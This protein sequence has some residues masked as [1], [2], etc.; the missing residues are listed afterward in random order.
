MTSIIV[1]YNKKRVKN[2]CIARVTNADFIGMPVPGKIAHKNKSF[3]HWGLIRC[4]G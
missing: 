1:Y 3:I 2:V 4:T